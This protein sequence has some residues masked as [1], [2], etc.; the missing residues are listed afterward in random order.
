V[1]FSEL[2]FVFKFMNQFSSLKKTLLMGVLRRPGMPSCFVTKACKTNFLNFFFLLCRCTVVSGAGSCAYS[3]DH[4]MFSV[5]SN[6]G[7]A[8]SFY[9]TVIF[10]LMFSMPHVWHSREVQLKYLSC[11]SG[12]GY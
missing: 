11:L 7:N 12:S 5:I 2:L 9:Y 1:L 6:R 4:L 10:E 8:L 3:W